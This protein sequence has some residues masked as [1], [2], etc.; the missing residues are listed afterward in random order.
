MPVPFEEAFAEAM[1]L[2]DEGRYEAAVT[3]L[4]ELVTDRIDKRWILAGVQCQL[5]GIYTFHL[6]RPE[7]GEA[8]F[9]KAVHLKPSSELASLGLF[10]ALLAQKKT[11]EAVEEMFRFTA[12]YPSQEYA[13]LRQETAASRDRD[14]ET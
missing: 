9:R 12:A 2:R 4:E 8:A 13:Q 3:L 1:K 10:H 11:R 7:R 6:R 5:G 14:G